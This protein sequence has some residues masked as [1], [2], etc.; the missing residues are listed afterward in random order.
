MQRALTIGFVLW[1]AI[2]F[3]TAAH[4][5][6]QTTRPVDC[7]AGETVAATMA[8]AKP[9]DTLT[10]RGVCKET[11]II[12]AELTGITLN[13][14]GAAT[15]SHPTGTTTPGPAAHVVYIRGRGITVAGFRILGGVDGIHLSGPA[16]AVI[17][18]NV[19]SGIRAAAS[20]STRAAWRRFTI[21]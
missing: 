15:I 1:T 9:G 7:S 3:A 10:V 20:M 11:V 8:A 18:G 2:T 13:G 5:I 16:H 4:A 21:T 14:Q 17:H 12:P 6:A 19:I